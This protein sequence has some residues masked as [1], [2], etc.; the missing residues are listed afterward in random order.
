MVKVILALVLLR[1][2]VFFFFFQKCLV[3]RNLLSPSSLLWLHV[4][5]WPCDPRITQEGTT[6]WSVRFCGWSCIA[7]GM[8]I[9]EVQFVH[10]SSLEHHSDTTAGMHYLCH[11]VAMSKLTVASLSFLLL[12][13]CS[14]LSP[15]RT[16]VSLHLC[17]ENFWTHA[18]DVGRVFVH[19]WSTTILKKFNVA[20]LEELRSKFQK[21]CYIA[22][23]IIL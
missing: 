11:L 19:I 21:T 3:F 14:S 18:C 7:S 1:H 6:H 10:S 13:S 15:I 5:M 17:K 2:L 16:M 23:L 22:K 12:D 4:K 8:L 9:I 20:Y